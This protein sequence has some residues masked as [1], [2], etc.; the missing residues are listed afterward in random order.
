MDVN[1][2]ATR[3][4]LDAILDAKPGGSRRLFFFLKSSRKDRW[5]S[6]IE[7][8]YWI[9]ALRT[10][11]HPNRKS[12]TIFGWV[13]DDSPESGNVQKRERIL[14]CGRETSWLY[15][16]RNKRIILSTVGAAAEE[17]GGLICIHPISRRP[18][19]NIQLFRSVEHAIDQPTSPMCSI[20]ISI[21][22][23]WIAYRLGPSLGFIELEIR[24]P[25]RRLLY[26]DR[27]REN[28]NCITICE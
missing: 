24:T 14:T 17:G 26:S 4:L 19:L 16:T 10:H 8:Y 28:G 23:S 22:D 2:G 15:F 20:C 5:P 18:E 3:L 11:F 12:K 27:S 6:P 1:D 13:R 7:I 25:S 9:W 21:I